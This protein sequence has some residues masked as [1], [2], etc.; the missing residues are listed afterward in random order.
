LVFYNTAGLYACNETMKRVHAL[1]K[2]LILYNCGLNRYAFGALVKQCNALGNS[3]PGYCAS[4]YGIPS[5]PFASTSCAVFDDANCPVDTL[6]WDQ[7]REG[8]DDY[9]Y[10]WTLEQLLAKCKDVN[11]PEAAAGKA[12]LDSISKIE[13][14]YANNYSP[15]VLSESMVNF[16]GRR[17]DEMRSA[18]VKCI[19]ALK[20]KK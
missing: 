5:E 6:A 1:K 15:D 4:K 8:V 10:I 14:P 17:L 2:P 7:I 20:N 3:E 9:R 11:L 13:V 16:K 18:L 19:I 12:A